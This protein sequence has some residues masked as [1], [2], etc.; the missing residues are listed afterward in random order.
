M[1]GLDVDHGIDTV[2]LSGTNIILWLF[3]GRRFLI[4]RRANDHVPQEMEHGRAFI[5]L[6]K[7]ETKSAL[8]GNEVAS[9]HKSRHHLPPVCCRVCAR[10]WG[11]LS[12]FFIKMT[13]S[14]FLSRWGVAVFQWLGG[15]GPVGSCCHMVA[16]EY[17]SPSPDSIDIDRYTRINN[18]LLSSGQWAGLEQEQ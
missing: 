17:R 8:S 7:A 16:L 4:G 15:A 6:N 11:C 14:G 5:L 12:V 13:W 10:W 9:R 3:G 2:L 1:Y 18:L